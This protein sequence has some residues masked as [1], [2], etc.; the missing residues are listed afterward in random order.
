MASAEAFPSVDTG[1]IASCASDLTMIGSA[2]SDTQTDVSTLRQAVAGSE[3]W[4]GE[5]ASRWQTVVTGRADDANLTS[6]VV[7]KAGSLL[8]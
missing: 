3:Q 5:A 7:N 1:A 6:E 2:M 4:Q 8:Q